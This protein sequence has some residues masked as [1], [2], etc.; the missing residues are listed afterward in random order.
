MPMNE[1]KIK[2]QNPFY[3]YPPDDSSGLPSKNRPILLSDEFAKAAMQGMMVNYGPKDEF[4][5]EE[6]ARLAYEVADE[7]LRARHLYMAKMRARN[8]EC[9]VSKMRQ[10]EGASLLK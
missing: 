2:F 1:E 7:M 3:V 10:T 5:I 6:I 8:R 4:S 9:S